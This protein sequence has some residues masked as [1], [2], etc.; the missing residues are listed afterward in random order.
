MFETVEYP[1]VA[2]NCWLYPFITLSMNPSH[3]A[4]ISP[5]TDTEPSVW[6]VN[7]VR[8]KV[9]PFPPLQFSLPVGKALTVDVVLVAV[10]P[11]VV[12]CVLAVLVVPVLVVSVLVVAWD[13]AV[14]VVP[15]LAEALVDVASTSGG[16]PVTDAKSELI[17]RHAAVVVT[18]ALLVVT[19]AVTS[20]PVVIVVLVV[21]LSV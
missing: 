10:V 14:L 3:H 2:I 11:L 12:V 19:V 21:Q 17:L 13:V 1:S 8:G 18:E 16:V 4:A 15:V 7:C 5:S 20:Q 6:L 9:G